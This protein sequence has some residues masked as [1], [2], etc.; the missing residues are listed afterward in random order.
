M[1]KFLY[2]KPTDITAASNHLELRNIGVN[3][4]V[5]IDSHITNTSTHFTQAD[6]FHSN[7]QG[8]GTYNHPQIDTHINNASSHRVIND[9]GNSATELWS[10]LKILTELNLIIARIVA[11][12]NP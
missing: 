3:N 12:E 9:T 5:Q 8:V 11:L 7:I 1:S 2:K 4:H 6:I 10:S